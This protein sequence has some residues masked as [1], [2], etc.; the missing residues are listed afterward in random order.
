MRE[1]YRE[2]NKKYR[3]EK[4]VRKKCEIL[5][6]DSQNYEGEKTCVTDYNGK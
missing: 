5:N 2:R 4:K 6:Y 1:K 3:R